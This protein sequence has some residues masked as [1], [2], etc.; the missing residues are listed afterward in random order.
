MRGGI[1]ALALLVALLLAPP[2]AH[3]QSPEL[4]ATV[5]RVKSLF[6]QGRYEEAVPVAQTAVRLSEQE[7]GPDHLAN[8]EMLNNLAT[9]Y[10]AQGRYGEAEPFYQRS[11]NIVEKALGPDHPNLATSLN[12]LALLYYAQGRY[13]EAES[14]FK[15]ALAIRESVLGPEHL[16]RRRE[17]QQPCRTLPRRGPLRRGRAAL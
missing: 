12:N 10:N 4:Q 16:N 11:L 7:F 14:L 15:R 3:A 8:A 5:E 17:P 6:S 2:V 9:M 1:T 13:D